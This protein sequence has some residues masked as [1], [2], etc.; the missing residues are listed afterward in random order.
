MFL[1]CFTYLLS[2]STVV[3]YSQ[4]SQVGFHIAEEG[5][6]LAYRACTRQMSTILWIATRYWLTMGYALG[7]R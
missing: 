6:P 1:R 4:H 5:R 3:G 7:I 2:F